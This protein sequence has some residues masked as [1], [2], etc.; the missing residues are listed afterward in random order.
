MATKTAARTAKKSKKA[1]KKLPVCTKKDLR[2]PKRKRRKCTVPTKKTTSARVSPTGALAAP[3]PSSPT[4]DG[5]PTPAYSAPPREGAPA[6]APTSAK[7]VQSSEPSVPVA[8]GNETSAAAP[9][10]TAG[11]LIY[12]GKFGPDQAARLLFR[13]G[14]GPTRGQA[15]QLSQLGLEAA[16]AKLVSPGAPQLIGPAPSGSYLV[17]GAFAPKDK[18][19]HLHL[20]WLDRMV[21]S[22]DSLGERMT[23]ILHDWFGVSEDGSQRHLMVDQIAMLRR[24]WRGSFRELLLKVTSD[25]AMLLF[26]NGRGS[27]KKSP[28][29][30][31]ARELM[32]LYALGA[33]RG[34]FTETDVR[35]SARAF[36][37]F[38]SDW[39]SAGLAVNFRFDSNRFDS[40]TKKLFG[41]TAYERS[42]NLDWRAA[43]HAI[44]DHPMHASFVVQKLWSYFIPSAPSPDTLSYLTNLYRTSGES[45]TRLVEA[46]LLHPDLYVGASLVKPP[47]VFT[48]GLLRAR[49]LGVNTDRWLGL[50]QNQGQ[51]LG[52]PPSVSGWNDQAWL[53]TSTFSARWEAVR[54]IYAPT[55]LSSAAYTSRTTET[56]SEAVASAL[57]F[58][59][60]PSISPAHRK[61]LEEIAGQTW[62][63]AVP[64]DTYGW[65]PGF[66][67]AKQNILRQLVVA[68]PDAQVC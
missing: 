10:R 13:A 7:P 40:G 14:F 41:G 6:S 20:E 23:L 35:E 68:A 25:P 9:A 43:V 18:Y 46:I 31:F 2:K 54:E 34:A 55:A 21:R 67:T 47:V 66:L 30:N 38:I 4:G 51:V 61:L 57:D 42:G 63:G 36:T 33:D 5:F 48:A 49:G 8:S 53:N 29:E 19:G 44:V 65:L 27:W 62:G 11:G 3:Q 12:E 64:G 37:G 28:N 26:L 1:S 58:W 39:D 24:E 32:E 60:N 56:P 59:G 16:V 45:L 52:F 50:L 15:Q 22:T 17:G